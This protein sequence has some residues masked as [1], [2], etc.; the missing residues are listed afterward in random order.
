VSEWDGRFEIS[1]EKCRLI[2]AQIGSIFLPSRAWRV[3]KDFV[4]QLLPKLCGPKR[5]PK[6]V[7]KA[8]K[9]DSL[10]VRDKSI[11]SSV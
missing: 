6:T 2:R 7:P 8:V 1:E 11:D 3:S 5:L 10:I 9:Y 4:N